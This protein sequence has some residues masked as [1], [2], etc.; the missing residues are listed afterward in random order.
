M[1]GWHHQL[2]GHEFEQTWGESEG[3]GD[4]A[5]CSPWGCKELDMTEVTQHTS[6][7]NL[8]VTWEEVVGNILFGFSELQNFLELY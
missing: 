1:A 4:L 6:T 2:N 7:A 3:Q 8:R 5:C